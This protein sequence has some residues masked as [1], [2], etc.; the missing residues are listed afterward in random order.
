MSFT[1]Y[2]FKIIYP[3]GY[4]KKGLTLNECQR[5]MNKRKD[6]RFALDK[7]REL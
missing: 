6:V 4:V 7:K 2:L 5:I 1:I 3:S